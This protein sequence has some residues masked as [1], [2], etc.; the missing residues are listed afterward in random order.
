MT[1]DETN[2]LADCQTRNMTMDHLTP[3]YNMG[4]R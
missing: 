2:G 4:A 3:D 1:A